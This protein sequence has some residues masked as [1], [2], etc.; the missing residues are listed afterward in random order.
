MPDSIANANY[1]SQSIKSQKPGEKKPKT[2]PDISQVLVCFFFFSLSLLINDVWSTWHHCFSWRNYMHFSK[3]L[4]SSQPNQQNRWCSTDL[5][6]SNFILQ[7][8][9]LQPILSCTDYI[10]YISLDCVVAFSIAVCTHIYPGF[11]KT[12]NCI[13]FATVFFALTLFWLVFLSTMGLITDLDLHPP[14]WFLVLS[15]SHFWG[16]FFSK[17]DGQ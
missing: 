16:T 9:W 14:C 2:K 11:L 1:T 12:S 13:N 7:C 10:Q 5:L 15:C 4:E 8:M 6:I 17:R 3:A